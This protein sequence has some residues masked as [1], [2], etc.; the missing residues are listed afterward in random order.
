MKHLLILVLALLAARVSP[1]QSV[2]EIVHG[3]AYQ[4]VIFPATVKLQLQDTV[5]RWTPT[6]ADI[7]QLERELVVFMDKQPR[8]S[9]VNDK[10]FGP[11]IH[12]QLRGYT[13]QY[14]GYISP[15]GE[16]II[17]INC[18]WNPKDDP[19]LKHW[20]TNLVQVL[21]G[22]SAFWHIHYNTAKRRFAGLAIN[23]VA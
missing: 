2:G 18:F 6:A 17:Y 7:E 15:Q 1:A 23:G 12:R 19:F 4:G 22:G 9:P 3:G 10:T 13:R 8:K 20:S 11:S 21:D 5:R 16:K 14:V